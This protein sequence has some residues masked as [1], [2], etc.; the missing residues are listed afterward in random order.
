MGALPAV[1]AG[2]CVLNRL[3][4]S[5]CSACVEACPTRALG[6]GPEG[7][8]ALVADDCTGCAG[9]AAACPAGA[10]AVAGA[11]PPPKAQPDRAGRVLLVCPQRGG[12]TCLQALGLEALAR[13]WRDGVR[14]IALAV[15]DCAACA[16]GATL[17]FE[18][19]LAAFNALL[20]DRGM[21]VLCAAPATDECRLARLDAAERPD[22]RR[23]AFLAPLLAS[24]EALPALREVQEAGAGRPGRRFAFAPA[25]DPAACSGCGA[26]V[27]LCPA[28]AMTLINT[29]RHDAA[30][31]IRPEACTGCRLC[32]DVC[33]EGAVT[34][35]FLAPAAP[36]VALRPYRC[37][38]CGV[39]GHSPGADG[40]EDG[41]C[42]VCRRAAHYRKL[43]VIQA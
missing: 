14:H 4:A 40:P 3:A 37:A 13:L 21:R 19:L 35:R 30:Y 23:R 36:P 28:A 43:H 2:L 6:A 32:A 9:C 20:A 5:R 16:N 29:G 18:A 27:N 22:A 33:D 1:E 24:P 10:I 39:P 41:L 38:G 42:P 8:L 11:A 17:R 12:G 15:G 25:I 26:C 31:E 7:A 34:L